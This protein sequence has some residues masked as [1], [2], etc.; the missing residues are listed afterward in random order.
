MKGYG[1]VGILVF[2]WVV[3]C[4]VFM[5]RADGGPH[6][7]SSP[8]MSDCLICH[9]AHEAR[10]TLRENLRIVDLCLACHDAAAFG[11]HTDVM[12][13]LYQGGG[14]PRGLRGG[15]FVYGWMKTSD[16][17]GLPL[18]RPTT[19][20]HL[21]DS[22]EGIPWGVDTPGGVMSRMELSCLVCHNPHGRSGPD[23]RPTYR[24]LR[25]TPLGVQ[26]L[27]VV[28]PDE[29]QK[30]YMIDDPSGR[31]F[32]QRYPLRIFLQLAYWC[33]LCHQRYLI[34]ADHRHRVLSSYRHVTAGWPQ[35][36]E[37]RRTWVKGPL[38]C[39]TCYVA[40]GTTARMEGYAK[41]VSLPGEEEMLVGDEYSALL[42]LDNRGVCLACHRPG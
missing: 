33:A 31:Y 42:R 10:G 41:Q 20:T 40:H 32:G 30:R 7:V 13:G 34:T 16:T 24:V 36:E 11:S 28:V 14:V 39:L 29:E 15:G 22:R 4:Q 38:S 6:G 25:P 12:D 26:N 5:A 19:S 3:G 17:P 9:R 35:T 1:C 21:W 37:G 8:S 18:L 23:G 27:Y 2:A